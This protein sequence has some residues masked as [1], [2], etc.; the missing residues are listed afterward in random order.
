M[1]NT[2]RTSG[3]HSRILGLA[4]LLVLVSTSAVAQSRYG[5][6]IG[7]VTDPSNAIVRDASV[8][9]TNDNTGIA[10]VVKTGADV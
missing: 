6:I 4:A 1:G 7:V 8:Q 9:A 5:S 3:W 2:L 10:R